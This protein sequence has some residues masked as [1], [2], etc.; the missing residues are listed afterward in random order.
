M[1]FCFVFDMIPIA[2]LA[3]IC[4]SRHDIARV[5]FMIYA[6]LT[7]IAYLAT[8]VSNS[9]VFRL[10]ASHIKVV[11]LLHDKKKLLETRQVAIAALTQAI[12]PLVCQVRVGGESSK[13][14]LGPG[15]L[16]P[17]IFSTTDTADCGREDYFDNA[18]LAGIESF[19]GCINHDVRRNR[20]SITTF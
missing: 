15:I 5:L 8:F 19:I 13:R 7:F 1:L 11:Q 6:F 20:R 9:L 16:N 10:V 2:L 4:T 18:I 17:V 12:V 3:I 14:V